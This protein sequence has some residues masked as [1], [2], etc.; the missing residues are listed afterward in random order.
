M[1][2]RMVHKYHRVAV[3][4]FLISYTSS[5][6]RPFSTYTAPCLGKVI[7]LDILIIPRDTLEQ[8]DRALIWS[9]YQIRAK[10]RYMK[11]PAKVRKV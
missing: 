6:G 10:S 8:I 2:H 11:R 4:K 5:Q 3:T 7:H 1:K 9:I